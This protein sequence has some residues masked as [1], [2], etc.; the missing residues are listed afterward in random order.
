MTFLFG[1]CLYILVTGT[2]N[3]G[4]I[5]HRLRRQFLTWG[6]YSEN[7]TEEPGST[8]GGTSAFLFACGHTKPN[9]P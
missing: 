6:F 3:D 2:P 1:L 8:P 9:L 5:V 4:P 7:I